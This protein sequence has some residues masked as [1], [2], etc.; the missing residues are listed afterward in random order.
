MADWLYMHSKKKI[1]ERNL[2]TIDLP[3]LKNNPRTF[4]GGRFRDKI[5]RN[6]NQFQK[7]RDN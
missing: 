4:Q 6:S 1:Q 2:D 7:Q 3:E 5:F